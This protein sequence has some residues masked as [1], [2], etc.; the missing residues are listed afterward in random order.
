MN[1]ACTNTVDIDITNQVESLNN[2]I[3]KLQCRLDAIE[4]TL[5]SVDAY[6]R[7]LQG[8]D[9]SDWEEDDMDEPAS[10][11]DVEQPSAE[12]EGVQQR[13]GSL[14]RFLCRRSS[15]W[16]ESPSRTTSNME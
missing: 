11:E 8:D 10:D 16:Q 14:D 3:A 4:G 1:C 13:V 6:V 12:D 2:T 7:E 9:D 15:T 5:A